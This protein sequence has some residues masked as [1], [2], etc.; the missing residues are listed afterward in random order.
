MIIHYYFIFVTVANPPEKS[1]DDSSLQSRN[2]QLAREY[3][4]ISVNKEM[5]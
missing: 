4:S 2:G 3:H 5:I 1:K